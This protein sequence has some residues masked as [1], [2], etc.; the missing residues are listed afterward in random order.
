MSEPAIAKSILQNW[1]SSIDDEMR[2]TLELVVDS[3]KHFRSRL[4]IFFSGKFTTGNIKLTMLGKF[5]ALL[6]ML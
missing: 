3:E 2:N 1:V 4:R 6:G 5:R